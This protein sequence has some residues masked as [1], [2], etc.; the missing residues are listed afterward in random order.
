MR[1]AVSFVSYTLQMKPTRVKTFANSVSFGDE[2]CPG[3]LRWRY[4]WQGWVLRIQ[5]SRVW[6]CRDLV[7]E[8]G[9]IPISW[10]V[11]DPEQE[12]LFSC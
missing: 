8:G 11:D 6:D 4:P 2:C 5:K 12:L 10:L 3:N 7:A 9:R 1:N